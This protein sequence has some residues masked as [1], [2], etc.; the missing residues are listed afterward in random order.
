MTTEWNADLIGY[1]FVDE[2]TGF[3]H[4]VT[5]NWALNCQYV[6]T[7]D[8]YQEHIRN[9]GTVRRRKEIEAEDAAKARIAS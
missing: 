5:G 3:T 6:L 9:A 1:E 2:E 4:R 7:F 8:G